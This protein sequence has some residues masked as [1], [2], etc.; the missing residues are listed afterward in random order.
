MYILALTS[1]TEPVAWVTGFINYIDETYNQYNRGKFGIK[2]S[3]HITIKLDMVLI[4]DVVQP[5]MG[6]T[7]YLQ[8]GNAEHI[9]RVVFMRYFYFWI[10][11]H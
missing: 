2:K 8:A 3:W 7:N 5:Q 4:R 11:C 10:E 1:I 6:A 9:S